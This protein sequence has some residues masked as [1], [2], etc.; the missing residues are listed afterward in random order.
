MDLRC[1]LKYETEGLF[2]TWKGKEFQRDG[3]QF[4][5]ELEKCLID[6]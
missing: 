3:A 5:K 1:F 6:L 4:L 2:L